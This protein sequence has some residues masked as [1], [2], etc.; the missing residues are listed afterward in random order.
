MV[1]CLAVRIDTPSQQKFKIISTL[2]AAIRVVEAKRREGMTLSALQVEKSF[3]FLA[4]SAFHG[5]TEN[6]QNRYAVAGLIESKTVFTKQTFL[7]PV[8]DHFAVGKIQ[9]L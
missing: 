2:Y 8:V 7:E 3:A 9:A 5:L 6:V 1:N 4:N